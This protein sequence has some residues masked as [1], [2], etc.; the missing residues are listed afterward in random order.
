MVEVPYNVCGWE[1]CFDLADD[2]YV[3]REESLPNDEDGKQEG[4]EEGGEEM[5]MSGVVE[6]HRE[7][8]SMG[9]EMADARI[10][11]NFSQ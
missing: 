9:K 1:F 7:V 4:G 6:D 10:L 2:R 11:E 8:V 5:F 3:A